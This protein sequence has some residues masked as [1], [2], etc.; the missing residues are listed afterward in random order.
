MSDAVNLASRLEGANKF[1]GT[2]IIASEA[3]VALAGEAFAWRELD[4]VRVKGRVQA[5]TI[6]Q[7][8]ARSDGLTAAQQALAGHYAEGLAHWRAR[9]FGL[10][11]R[12][13]D[14]SAEIDRPSRMFRER[15]RE[16]AQN[17]PAEDWDSVRTLQEK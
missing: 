8:L 7:L 14:R 12:S 2:T 9:E 4:A 5:L 15:A 17:P 13:F 3:T 11:A 10:A 1:Y 6:Y 16:L